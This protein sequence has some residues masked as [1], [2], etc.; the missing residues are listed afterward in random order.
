M[1]SKLHDRLGTAGFVIALIALVAAL[2]G[3]AYAASGGLTGKQKK[4]VEKISKKYAGKP[5]AKGKQGPAGTSGPKGD[6]GAAGANGTSGSAGTKGEPGGRGEEGEPGES[7]L[8]G[9]SVLNG[10]TVPGAGLGTTGDFYIDTATNEIYGPKAGTNWGTPTSLK[11]ES[12]FTETLPSGKTETGVYAAGA[13]AGGFFLEELIFKELSFPIPLA[14]G[15]EADHVKIVT[16]SAPAECENASHPGL[17]SEANPEAAPGYLCIFQDIIKGLTFEEASA[18]GG[19]NAVG[20]AG[21]LLAYSV[22]PTATEA[23]TRGSWAVTAP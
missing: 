11:G 8:N 23:Y 10:T 1:M 4:E 18:P 20:T 5:G 17:A 12:G 21:T 2:G 22:S 6:T 7:G 15:I 16:G 3:G 19:V 13:E 14:A 9:K